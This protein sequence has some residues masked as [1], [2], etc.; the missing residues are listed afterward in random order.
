MP[1]PRL[2]LDV[3]RL[4][5]DRLADD[6]TG[7]HTRLR[8]T[9]APLM[10]ICKEWM[11]AV[12]DVV[13]HEVR[14][15][16]RNLGLLVRT[17]LHRQDLLDRVRVVR[18]AADEDRHKDD[19]NGWYTPP[20]R[21]RIMEEMQKLYSWERLTLVLHRAVN[22]TTLE[23]PL[24]SAHSALFTAVTYAVIRTTIVALVVDIVHT[25]PISDFGFFWQS[26]SR[27]PN[28][29]QLRIVN[30]FWANYWNVGDVDIVAIRDLVIDH[31]RGEE[32]DDF[33]RTDLRPLLQRLDPD[34]LR[35]LEL[36]DVPM[37]NVVL[38]LL[39]EFHG[40]TRLDIDS[41]YEADFDGALPV[42]CKILPR[43]PRLVELN[44]TGRESALISS[45]ISLCNFLDALPRSVKH[46]ELEPVVF[47][48]WSGGGLTW[49]WPDAIIDYSAEVTVWLKCPYSLSPYK[50]DGVIPGA[51]AYVEFRVLRFAA[52]PYRWQGRCAVS[53]DPNALMRFCHL[54]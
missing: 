5:L 31:S 20:P 18:I 46:C 54:T 1:V 52:P 22:I 19:Q 6:M 15:T 38:E 33:D 21:D 2:P 9:L 41:S 10:M 49:T 44:L 32:D 37:S 16:K 36:V 43:L 28:L 17:L 48:D 42:L 50:V 11:P 51:S 23:L 34:A 3:V 45:P 27:L 8:R 25:V 35:T 4:V 13:W 30:P 39:G 24:S 47:A 12:L 53:L 40:L 26:L 29:S 7:E 14:I